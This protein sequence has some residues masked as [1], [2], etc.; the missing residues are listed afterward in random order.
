M[1]VAFGLASK[2][3]PY[4]QESQPPKSSVKKSNKAQALTVYRVSAQELLK[5]FGVVVPPAADSRIGRSYQ[6]PGPLSRP[7]FVR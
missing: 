4:L 1:R 2:T 3:K 5:A 7:D 6:A